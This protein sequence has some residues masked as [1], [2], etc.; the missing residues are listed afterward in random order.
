[1]EA[2]ALPFISLNLI[3]GARAAQ[4][5][6]WLLAAL[7]RWIHNNAIFRMLGEAVKLHAV[8]VVGKKYKGKMLVSGYFGPQPPGTRLASHPVWMA[9]LSHPAL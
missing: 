8:G 7:R 1:M 4:D 6:L 9:C 5:P 2:P 3:D